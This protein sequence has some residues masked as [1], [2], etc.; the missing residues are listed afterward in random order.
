MHGITMLDEYILYKEFG[1]N[2]ELLIDH[3][4]GIETCTIKDI[5]SKVNNTDIFFLNPPTS[6]SKFNSYI[7]Y[8]ENIKC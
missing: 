6:N 3:A 1:V 2:A 8:K 7:N 4:N 5:Q